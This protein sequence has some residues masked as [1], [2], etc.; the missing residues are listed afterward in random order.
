MSH[1]PEDKFAYVATGDIMHGNVCAF[2]EGDPVPEGT[3]YDQG[4]LDTDPPMVVTRDKWDKRP[5]EEEPRPM[6][7]GEMPEH[8]KDKKADEKP[9][10]ST[11]KSSTKSDG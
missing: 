7:R 3:V 8:L 1:R 2:R 4:W 5:Q 11:K 6:V 9:A 10:A